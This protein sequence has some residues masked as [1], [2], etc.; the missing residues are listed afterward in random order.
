MRTSPTLEP[1]ADAAA[2]DQLFAASLT[3]P[4]VLFLHDP[5]CP[6]SLWAA[7]AVKQLHELDRVAVLDVSRHQPLGRLVEQR[8]GVRH[9]S[10]QLL[11]LRGGEAVWSASHGRI[12]A[13]AVRDALRSQACH[14]AT[15]AYQ[16]TR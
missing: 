16:S 4:Q 10:P 1:I 2:L 15:E 13:A 7:H 12:H 5:G 3:T 11:L 14:A 6:L 8:T 9:A